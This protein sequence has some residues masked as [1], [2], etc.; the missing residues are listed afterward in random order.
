MLDEKLA[1]MRAHRNNIHRYRRL[2]ETKLSDVYSLKDASERSIPRLRNCWTSP[3]RSISR[4][5]KL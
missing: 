4:R 2:L 3:S 5:R 1:R